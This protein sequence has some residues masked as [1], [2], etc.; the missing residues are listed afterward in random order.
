MPINDKTHLI[1]A[2][3][4]K[5]LKMDITLLSMVSTGNIHM[6]LI[7]LSLGFVYSKSK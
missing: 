7:L 1:P 5:N 6:K 4:W 3:V 2:M